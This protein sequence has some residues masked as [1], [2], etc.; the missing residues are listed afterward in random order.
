[1]IL[2]TYTDD[3]KTALTLV[4]T[5]KEDPSL[6]DLFRL[7]YSLTAADSAAQLITVKA[8]AA[9]GTDFHSKLENKMGSTVANVYLTSDD[10][11][12]FSEQTLQSVIASQYQDVNFIIT[13]ENRL[14]IQDLL[15]KALTS[16]TAVISSAD[17]M[18][19]VYVY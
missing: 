12:E 3:G 19:Q 5:L 2:R 14:T 1:M 16:G 11:K 10:L 9:T 8:Q 6:F 15:E 17:D 13:S 4:Q 18:R 7:E